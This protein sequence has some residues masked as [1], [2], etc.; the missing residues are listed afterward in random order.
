MIFLGDTLVPD[1][2]IEST[3]GG[4]EITTETTTEIEEEKT[5][6]VHAIERGLDPRVT[7][8]RTNEDECV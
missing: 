8:D 3:E 6:M 2:E 1:P 7:T 5:H 4:T